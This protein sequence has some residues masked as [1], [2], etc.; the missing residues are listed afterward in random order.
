METI[1][2]FL[3]ENWLAP[4]IVVGLAAAWLLLRTPGTR[5]ASTEEFDQRIG[6]GRPLI[7]E[8]FSNT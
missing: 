3:R 1:V 7:V 4:L 2:K 6:A 8:F 5:L